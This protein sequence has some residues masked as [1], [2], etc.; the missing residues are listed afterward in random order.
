MKRKINFRK[1]IVLL[2]I[3]YVS[4]FVINQTISMH[5]ISSEINKQKHIANQLKEEQGDLKSKV[6]MAETDKYKEVLSRE[7]LNLVKDGETPVIDD[8]NNK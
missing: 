5:R 8:Q 2:L 7:L 4:Y 1:I 6:E 3:F